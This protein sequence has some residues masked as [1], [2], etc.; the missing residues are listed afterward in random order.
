LKNILANMFLTAGIVLAAL[1]GAVCA[2]S[3]TKWA[4]STHAGWPH[5]VAAVGIE[6]EIS[7]GRPE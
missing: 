4:A 1:P 6:K 3:S 7:E 2:Q 5:A